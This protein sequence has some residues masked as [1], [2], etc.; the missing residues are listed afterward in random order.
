ML[1][2]IVG[3]LVLMASCAGLGLIL[4]ANA[5]KEEIW[6]AIYEMLGFNKRR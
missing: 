3:I 5:H 6:E 4:I 2:I 1:E